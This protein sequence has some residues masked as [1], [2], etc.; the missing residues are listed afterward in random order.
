MF[1]RVSSQ[2]Y[3]AHLS[4]TEMYQ[5]RENFQHPNNTPIML[6]NCPKFCLFIVS[7]HNLLMLCFFSFLHNLPLI[8]MFLILCSDVAIFNKCTH[9]KPDLTC[10]LRGFGFIGQALFIFVWDIVEWALLWICVLFLAIPALL[11]P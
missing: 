4:T 3:I 8:L 2:F 5:F 10:K 6:T 11:C 7:S 1:H 9:F